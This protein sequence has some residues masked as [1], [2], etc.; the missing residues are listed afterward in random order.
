MVSIRTRGKR[1]GLGLCTN[2]DLRGR[3][4]G[5]QGYRW[6]YSL[7]GIWQSCFRGIEESLE[8][9]TSMLRAARRSCVAPRFLEST[10]LA[11]VRAVISLS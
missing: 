8:V 5:E 6:R 11:N 10:R 2:Q 9:A 4:C 3:C 1:S 7:N